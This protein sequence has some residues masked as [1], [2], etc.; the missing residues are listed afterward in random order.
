M[1]PSK[2]DIEEFHLNLLRKSISTFPQG[3]LDRTESPDFILNS[4]SKR[5]GIEITQLFKSPDSSGKSLQVQENEKRLLVQE[6]LILYH[7]MNQPA[8]EVRFIFGAYTSFNKKNRTEFAQKISS[9]VAF[10]VPVDNEWVR[11]INK[12]ENPSVFPY[13]IDS[14]SIARYGHT[15][16]FWSASG[17]GWVQEDFAEELQLLI[18]KKNQKVTKYR[19]NCDFYWLVI[20]IEGGSEATFFDPSPKTL[21]HIYKSKYDKIFLFDQIR[22][23]GHEL[24]ITGAA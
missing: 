23:K 1:S 3:S 2:K 11:L 19:H 13:E 10:N 18:D 9:L 15:K 16:N 14:I 5:I 12:F 8:I 6:S 4:E 20:V 21:N 17:A 22:A 7:Q 24:Q